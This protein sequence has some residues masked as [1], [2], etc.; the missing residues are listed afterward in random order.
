M[1]RKQ[2]LLIP[3]LLV[4]LVVGG[5]V[6]HSQQ[7]GGKLGIDDSRAVVFTFEPTEYPKEPGPLKMVFSCEP[8]A[9][10]ADCSH[11]KLSVRT[12]GGLTCSGPVT[13]TAEA[14]KGEPYSTVLEVVVPPSDTSS[15]HVTMECGRVIDRADAYFVVVGDS[16]EF[17]KGRPTVTPSMIAERQKARSDSIRASMSPEEL[18]VEYDLLVDLRV[19]APWEIDSA[20]QLLAPLTP[21]DEDSVYRVRTTKA[22][23]FKLRDWSIFYKILQKHGPV[24]DS[25]S[26]DGRQPLKYKPDSSD[27]QGALDGDA[28]LEFGTYIELDYVEGITTEQELPTNQ[29][30]TFYLRLVNNAGINM[31]GI[32]NGFRVYS[33]N[34]AARG[35]IFS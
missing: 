29:D 31:D 27:Q 30:I 22:K 6:G 24:S 11:M 25:S 8:V 5:G 14:H 4:G 17:W 35:R 13:W 16:V 15:I 33:P 19:G 28:R 18:Q 20:R 23:M 26:H 32:M 12:E 9:S 3:L 7:L 1:C 10:F 2:Y 34:G 21:T